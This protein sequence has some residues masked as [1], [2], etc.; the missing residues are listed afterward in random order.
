MPWKIFIINLKAPILY[1]VEKTLNNK[2]TL[3][4]GVIILSLKI[5]IIDTD[6]P[7]WN[8]S[9][10]QPIDEPYY[11]Y[12]AYNYFETGTLFASDGA[13]LSGSPLLTNIITY[14]S[15][16]TFGDNYLG[17]RFSSL[18]FSIVAY[19]LFFLLLQRVTKNNLLKIGAVLFFTLNFSFTTAN[20]IVEPTIA[21]MMAAMLVLWLVVKWKEKPG[22]DSRS[23]IWKSSIVCLLFL[24]SY[25]TNAFLIGAAYISLIIKNNPSNLKVFSGDRLKKI[26]IQ[27]LYFVGGVIVSFW[28]YYALIRIVG[29]NLVEDIILATST[30]GDRVAIGPMVILMNWIKLVA[31]NFFRF[32][33]L[34][35]VLTVL[36]VLVILVKDRGKSKRSITITIIFVACFVLQCAFLNDFP[37]RKLLI[38][39]PFLILLTTY[40]LEIMWDKVSKMEISIL[41]WF[42]FF[43]VI[44]LI[45]LIYLERDYFESQYFSLITTLFGVVLLLTL[46]LTKNRKKA[47][48]Y[49]LFA[50]L[51]FPEIALFTDHY[52]MQRTYHYKNTYKSLNTY[53]GENFIGGYS[54]GFRVNN[55]IIPHYNFYFYRNEMDNFWKKMDSLSNNG[56]HDYSIGY[57]NEEENFRKIGFEPV[58]VLMPSDQTVYHLDW[59][60]YEE[61]R[62]K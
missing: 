52:L 26:F 8:V 42:V 14:L 27:S 11:T 41:S 15:L 56:L 46:F 54:M 57:A 58:L 17:L 21:R 1:V 48:S 5:L 44:P 7:K 24:I 32:N 28:L 49:L 34:F 29:G 53:N 16:K 55:N 51:L 45:L 22:D 18:F 38:L 31:G 12:L 61:V 6:P 35:L 10:Y 2:L 13:V 30:Y 20:I 23:L 4:V 37:Q 25:P 43:S 47:V 9:L 60:L 36:S 62:D 19:I 33:P 39:L 3:L 50:L 40:G 59:I